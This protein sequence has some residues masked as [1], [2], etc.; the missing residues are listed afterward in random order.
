MAAHKQSTGASSGM[1]INAPNVEWLLKTTDDIESVKEIIQYA[2]KV[3]TTINP[4]FAPDSSN[5]EGAPPPVTQPHICNKS[6]LK[7]EEDHEHLSQL[8]ATC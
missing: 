6:H 7:V 2:N 1:A 5:V 3:V 4:A 8:I